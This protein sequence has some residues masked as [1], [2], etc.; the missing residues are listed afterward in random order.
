MKLLIADD[1]PLFRLAVTQALQDLASERGFSLLETDSLDGVR[2]LLD[3]HGDVELVLLDLMMPGSTGPSAVGHI[4]AEFP[5]V[6]VAVISA[7]SEREVVRRALRL[8][9]LGFIPKSSPLSRI[10]E[11]VARLLSGD[12]WLPPE[13]DDSPAPADAAL[14]MRLRQLTP[15]QLRVLE[16]VAEGKLNKQI[17]WELGIQETTIKQHVSAILKKLGFVNRTQAGIA[18]KQ[19]MPA[20]ERPV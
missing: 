9:A 16:M 18:L 3:Q 1:H 6:A 15:Q 13:F 20:L 17:A 5:A 2:A 12:S 7:H 4:R 8:G 11:A 10:Q 14:T 19:L